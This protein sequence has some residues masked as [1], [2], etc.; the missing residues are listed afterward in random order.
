[1]NILSLIRFLCLIGISI[2]LVSCD[3]ERKN[4]PPISIFPLSAEFALGEK[5]FRVPLVNIALNEKRAT[6]VI[7][8]RDSNGK[9]L[10]HY[11]TLSY[12]E[13]IRNKST[14]IPVSALEFEV[15]GYNIF[16]EERL[17]SYQRMESELCPVLPQI[18]AKV[19]CLNSINGLPSLRGHASHIWFVNLNHINALKSS[20]I[21]GSDKSVA[22]LIKELDISRKNPQRVCGKD[23][24]GNISSL[25]AAVFPLKNDVLAV[26]IVSLKG[27]MKEVLGESKFIEAL[28]N[29]GISEVENYPAFKKAVAAIKD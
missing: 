13:I 6:A 28:T 24:D 10:K 21:A 29:Y 17:D 9:S 25:C 11:C 5:I 26:W 27:G 23:E 22:A 18:W 7:P 12:E 14:P 16:R 2:V 3:D 8:C 19:S 1:M 15:M 4:T 20:W